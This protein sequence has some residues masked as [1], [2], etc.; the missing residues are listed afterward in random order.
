MVLS[1]RLSRELRLDY[2]LCDIIARRKY[3][4]RARPYFTLMLYFLARELACFL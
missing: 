2:C 3:Y 1:D 4:M